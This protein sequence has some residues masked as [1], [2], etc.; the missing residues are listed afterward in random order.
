[1]KDG[2]LWQLFYVHVEDVLPRVAI[3][4][5]YLVPDHVQV[6]K[7]LSYEICREIHRRSD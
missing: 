2:P 5:T 1:M 3:N 6:V 4:S 7:S